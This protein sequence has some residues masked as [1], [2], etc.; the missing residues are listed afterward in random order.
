M[1]LCYDKNDL[2][3]AVKLRDERFNWL[4]ELGA[5]ELSQAP[6]DAAGFLFGYENG[7]ED[8]IRLVGHRPNMHD[9]PHERR[10]LIRLNDV[11]RRLSEYGVD[12][13]TPKTWI[14]GIDDALPDDLEF[15]LFVR[16]P[17]SSWKRGGKQ[18]K[19]RNLRE[20]ND[21]IELLRRA[22]GWDTPILARQWIDVAVAGKWTFGSA[23]QEIRTWI[24]DHRPVAWSFHYLHAVPQP[25]GFPPKDADLACLA[26]LA[27]RV[28]S[29][30][31][32]RLICADF[33]RDGRGAWHFLEAGPG[34]VCGTAH[35]A[36]FK[37]VTEIL[38]GYNEPLKS[39]AVGGKL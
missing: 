27:E 13:S 22:F 32:S 1:L 20:L 16:T 37:H 14:I 34:A 25:K 28:G 19:A 35:E 11:L 18:A 15:P 8:Y 17:K 9:R 12:V 31:G 33:V 6:T 5:I 4:H 24:V 38:R 30:F 36:V 7:E 3:H 23:P 26:D 10:E 39:D 29:A 2:I 21:E